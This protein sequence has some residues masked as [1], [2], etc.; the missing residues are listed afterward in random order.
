MCCGELRSACVGE[1]PAPYPGEV[2]GQ[3]EE[4]CDRSGSDSKC[5]FAC[6]TTVRKFKA[7][8]SDNK[9]TD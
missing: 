2:N 4:L 3:T 8:I 9:V 5:D 7:R 6:R 1:E